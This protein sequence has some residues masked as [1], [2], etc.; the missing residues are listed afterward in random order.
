MGVLGESEMKRL[1]AC[2]AHTDIERGVTLLAYDLLDAAAKNLWPRDCQ[3]GWEL[4]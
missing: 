4:A 2:A 3:K 1:L